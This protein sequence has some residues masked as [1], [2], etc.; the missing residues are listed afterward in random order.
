MAR[1]FPSSRAMTK[2]ISWSPLRVRRCPRVASAAWAGTRTHSVE[3]PRDVRRLWGGV[4]VRQVRH[5]C[6][7][8]PRRGDRRGWSRGR[9]LAGR[10]HARGYREVVRFLARWAGVVLVGVECTGSYGAGVTRALTDARYDVREVNRHKPFR[11]AEAR[12]DR[13]LRRLLHRRSGPGRAGYRRLRR[14]ATG[15]SRRYARCGPPGPRRCGNAP[16][17][18][19]RSSPY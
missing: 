12:K 5:G 19:T 11:P 9:R 15:S 14:E 4:G 8:P 2:S 18:S 6:R 3:P 17:R 16:R 1:A 7:H 13:R 10:S